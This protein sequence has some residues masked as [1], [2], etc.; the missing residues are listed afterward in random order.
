MR[1]EELARI[2]EI[3]YQVLRDRRPGTSFSF[4][5]PWDSKEAT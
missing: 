3:D 2:M 5:M 1:K 4:L